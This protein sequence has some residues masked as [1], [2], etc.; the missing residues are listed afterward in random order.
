MASIYGY[1]TQGSYTWELRLDY[2]IT[3]N[4]S[5]M[6]ST[7]ACDLYVYCANG[8]S[9]NGVPNEAYYEICGNRVYQT[10][11]FT[12]QDWYYLGSRTISNIAH[13]EDGT[14]NYTLSATWVTVNETSSTPASISLSKTIAFPNIAPPNDV[15]S[16]TISDSTIN[17]GDNLDINITPVVSTNYHVITITSGNNSTSFDIPAFASGDNSINNGTSSSSMTSQVVLNNRE[18][19]YGSPYGYYTVTLTP[20]NRTTNSVTVKCNVSAHLLASN[21]YTNYGVTCGLY[22]GGTWHDFTLVS[23]GTPWQGTS[24]ISASTII[25]VSGLTASQTS[26]TGIKFRAIDGASEY[27]GPSLSATNCS[28]LAII[29]SVNVDS[30]ETSEINIYIAPDTYG[31][32]FE[33]TK[34]SLSATVSLT[35]YDSSGTN[36]G[37]DSKTITLYMSESIGKPTNTGIAITSATDTE[38]IVT[39]TAPTT[40]YG[41]TVSDYII[42]TN[43]GTATRSGN[44]ITVTSSSGFGSGK[45]QIS[46]YAIDS[47]NFKSNT[48]IVEKITTTPKI[49]LNN[50][51]YEKII[52]N[53]KNIVAIYCGSTRI[54]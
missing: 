24:P 40:K 23:Y 49:L 47:R 29:S 9:Y 41:A 6:T 3:Q 19:T 15:S 43:K 52:S 35:T 36:I 10:Y 44:T 53:S 30:S 21:S 27:E 14:K 51:S 2:V 17:L 26:I 13:E 22:I 12:S 20:S 25:T 50:A 7:I 4:Q 45:V 38:I 5:A 39:I 46:A 42:S 37:S 1:A 32:W 11:N 48:A 18:S 54:M 33:P 34:T 28:D 31:Y 8:H 16:W